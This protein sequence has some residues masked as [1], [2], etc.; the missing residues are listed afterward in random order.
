MSIGQNIRRIRKLRDLTQTYVGEKVGVVQG[1][2]SKWEHNATCPTGDE[3]I[4]LAATLS[5][6]VEDLMRTRGPDGSIT[7]VLQG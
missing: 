4:A 7:L 2:I 3:L 5:C 1:T 6:S